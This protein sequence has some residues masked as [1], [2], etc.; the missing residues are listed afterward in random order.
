VKDR[1]GFPAVIFAGSKPDLRGFGH[2]DER[3]YVGLTKKERA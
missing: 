1:E 3:K 2:R